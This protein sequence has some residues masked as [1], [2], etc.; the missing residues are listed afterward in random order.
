MH[1][2]LTEELWRILDREVSPRFFIRGRYIVGAEEIFKLHEQGRFRPLLEG[3]PIEAITCR[4]RLHE[5]YRAID[6]KS[7]EFK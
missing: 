6:N 1:S 3:I 5:K 4:T 2:E 7:Q